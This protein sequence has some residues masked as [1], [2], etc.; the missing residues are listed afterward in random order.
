MIWNQTCFYFFWTK[1]RC[2]QVSSI[3]MVRQVTWFSRLNT[4]HSYCP[5]FRWIWYS[6]SYC[7]LKA[8]FWV[9]RLWFISYEAKQFAEL[10]YKLVNKANLFLFIPG[11]RWFYSTWTWPIG[12]GGRQWQHAAV[13]DQGRLDT[14]HKKQVCHAESARKQWT[15]KLSKHAAAIAR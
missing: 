7:V 5:V 10:S 1:F 12:L 11:W 2:F 6:D 13:E 8:T 4:R 9:K 14:R 3:L 15:L